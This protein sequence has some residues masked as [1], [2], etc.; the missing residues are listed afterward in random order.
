MVL[1]GLAA[2]V[3]PAHEARGVTCHCFKERDFIPSRPASAD[4]YILATA[5][6]SFLAA[7]ALIEKG[8]V[9]RL[10]MTGVTETDLWLSSYLSTVTDRSADQLLDA[11]DGSSSWSAAF[12]AV[13]L[14]TRALGAAFQKARKGKDADGMARALADKV[15]ERTFN[16]SGTTL[17]HLRESGA[18]IAESSLSLYLA[19]RL[20]QTPENILN[21]VRGGKKTWG[22]LFH[23]LGIEID[24]V[25]DLIAEAVKSREQ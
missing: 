20:K 15:M 11:R 14:D 22:S 7:A 18:G 9:V 8:K 12:D 19:A 23:T 5:R 1:F 2:I 13:D 3:L 17:T 25:G 24:T 6:N 4:P 10:R 16:A 21:E